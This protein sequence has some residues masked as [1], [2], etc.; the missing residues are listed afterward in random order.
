MKNIFTDLTPSFPLSRSERGAR[1]GGWGRGRPYRK[2]YIIICIIIL[3]LININIPSYSQEDTK[4]ADLSGYVSSLNSAIFETVKDP[5]II[6]YLVHNRLNFKAYLS[7]KLT[8]AAEARNRLFMGD[9][10]RLS[11]SY[12]ETIASDQGLA[13]LSWNIANERSFFIN[14]TIDRL[15]LDF[16][17]GKFQARVGRQRINWGQ[18]LVWNPNDIFNAYSYFDFDY[19]ERPG[20]DAI[21][22]QYYPGSS[23]TAELAIKANHDKK[24]TAAA[25]YRFNRWSYDWQVLAGIFEDDELSA[26]LG[27]SGAIGSVSF[28][29]EGTWFQPFKNFTDTAGTGLFTFG[30]DKIFENNSMIQAQV[31]FCNK[32]FGIDAASLYSSRNM[33]VKDLAFSKF[34]A[35]ASYSYPITPLFTA[36]LSGMWF[37]DREGFFTGLSADYSA[38]ENIDFTVLWQHFDGVFGTGARTKINLAFLRIKY[39]F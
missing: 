28:R 14:T 24:I 6:D 27:W 25:L 22:L 7:P 21:R 34:S 1:G 9:M 38:S 4:K 20:S 15:W 35:F 10:V 12:S 11:N 39:S 17:S 32:P 2:V 29:G 23:S 30:T 8:F 13:D 37:P 3:I 31:M 36:A 19:I 16:N 5:F 18:T 33:S 26:G